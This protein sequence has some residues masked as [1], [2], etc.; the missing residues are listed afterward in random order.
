[1][2]DYVLGYEGERIEI[3][4]E[5]IN[6]SV[7]NIIDY[8]ALE[9]MIGV[10]TVPN[11]WGLDNL[12]NNR[13]AVTDRSGAAAAEPEYDKVRMALERSTVDLAGDMVRIIETQRA[14]QLA[15]KIIQTSDEFIRIA[16]NLR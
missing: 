13:F 15:A 3:P 8:A 1:M 6:D 16:N 12:S 11:N 2:G 9:D 7:T 4:F 5:V 10:Y 14:Y